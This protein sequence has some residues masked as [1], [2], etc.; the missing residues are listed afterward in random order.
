MQ[1]CFTTALLMRLQVIPANFEYFDI[2]L[3]FVIPRDR[4]LPRVKNNNN[5]NNNNS[6]DT[7]HSDALTTR[8]LQTYACCSISAF[9]LITACIFNIFQFHGNAEVD[10]LAHR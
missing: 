8:P 10:S 9:C 2:D 4:M 6:Y 5:N 7:R 1:F 3:I